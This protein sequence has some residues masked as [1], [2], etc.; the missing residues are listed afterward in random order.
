ML[1][2]VYVSWDYLSRQEGRGGRDGGGRSYAWTDIQ[3]LPQLDA[4]YLAEFAKYF[5]PGLVKLCKAI[6]HD[7]LTLLEEMSDIL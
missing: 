6:C 5:I 1:Y 4:F 7:W 3:T 2:G